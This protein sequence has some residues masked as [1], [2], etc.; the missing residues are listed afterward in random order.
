[1]HNYSY[2]PIF[3]NE[4][5]FGFSRDAVYEKLRKNNIYTRRYFYPLI[6]QYPAYRSLSSANSHN[7]SVAEKIT[8]QVLCLPIYPDLEEKDI[9]RIINI[10]RNNK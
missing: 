1:M 2:F 8:K 3:I 5:E 9:E 4:K 7:L 6:S 10:L